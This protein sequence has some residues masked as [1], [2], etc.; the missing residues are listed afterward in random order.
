MTAYCPPTD[1]S[2]RQ[3]LSTARTIAVVGHSDKPNRA[4]SQVAQYMRRAGYQIYPVNPAVSSI[5]GELCYA[6]LAEVPESVD[7]VNVF[8]RSEFLPE[9]TEAAVKAQAKAV[10]AQLDIHHP[11]AVETAAAAGLVLVMDK[12]IKIEH[13]RLGI[14]KKL[15]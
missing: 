4:S 5:D 7:I 12:C 8:R 11:A 13:A 6:L 14:A 3:L 9:V 1:K 2:L 15:E 10:W